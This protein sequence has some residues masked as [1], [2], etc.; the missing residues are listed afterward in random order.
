MNAR[1]LGARGSPCRPAN[2]VERAPRAAIRKPRWIRTRHAWPVPCHSKRAD[3][4]AEQPNQYC[5]AIGRCDCLSSHCP[6]ITISYHLRMSVAKNIAVNSITRVWVGV[7]SLL[8]IPI[9]IHFMGIEAYGLVGF[10]LTLMAVLLVWSFG[11]S[12]TLLRGL[13]Q[14]SA[15]LR[16]SA[17]M[18][19]SVRTLETV[20]WGATAVI[21]T[22]TFLASGYL[23]Q[24]VRADSLSH[25]E[26]RAAIALMGVA[27]L[28]QGPLT[29][30][31]GGLQ[32]LDRQLLMNAILAVGT[33]LRGVFAVLVLWLVSPTV[34]AF[35]AAQAAVSLLQ[36]TAMAMAL[37]RSLP[38]SRERPR[39]RRSM[40][41]TLWRFT[42]GTTAISITAVVLTQTDK[43][44]VSR[45]LSLRDFGYYTIA[46]QIAASI[47][48]IVGPVYS[49]VF[50]RLSAL[51]AGTQ[52]DALAI[53]YDRACQ[54]LAILLLP[55]AAVIA[56]F[57]TQLLFIWTGNA[58]IAAET[59]SIVSILVAGSALNGLYVVPF[60]LQLAHGWTR[61]AL[62][63]N[64]TTIIVLV[65][66]VIWAAR[67]YGAVGAAAMWPAVNLGYLVVGIRLMHRRLLP[68]RLASWYRRAFLSPLTAVVS[69]VVAGRLLEPA[70]PSPLQLL[71]IGG[72]FVC[73]VAAAVAAT[74]SSH[75]LLPR[76][77]GTLPG[78]RTAN[79][80]ATEE[81]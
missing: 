34:V 22:A 47:A 12:T 50:P 79:L 57:S 25:S 81:P 62:I 30:Y 5:C 59:D 4:Y 9:Y 11:A 49:S 68:E 54:V 3:P 17:H 64:L 77:V 45:L 8:F 1:A 69:V 78:R 65:P 60:A 61:L 16:P 63:Q 31:Q 6:T 29:L 75:W 10:Y 27:L 19:D 72:V 15:L 44:L 32:G 38:D 53:L 55:T 46:G 36:T 13:A 71:W 26:L 2:F 74:G 35:F 33:T 23:A 39:F 48:L 14:D 7:V 52:T 24:W 51:S 58:H 70:M 37:W 21:G 20:Y 40:F 42:A 67:T 56:A 80:P 18:R 41:T 43:L 28:F 66:A 73:A 76:I